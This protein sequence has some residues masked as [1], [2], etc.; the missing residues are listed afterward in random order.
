MLKGSWPYYVE[1]E[2][3]EAIVAGGGQKAGQ[4]TSEK[5]S[6]RASVSLCQRDHRGPIFLRWDTLV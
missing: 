6:A 3:R 5:E 1:Y 2:S 4:P